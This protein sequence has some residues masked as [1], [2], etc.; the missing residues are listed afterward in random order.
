MHA[1]QVPAE[2]VIEREWDVAI[3]GCGPAGAVAAMELARRGVRVVA[4]ERHAFPRDKICGDALVPDACRVLERLGLFERVRAQSHVARR[5]LWI[6]PAGV[7]VPLAMDAL[8]AKRHAFD[9]LLAEAAAERGAV[10]ANANASAVRTDG[11][12]ATVHLRDG[13]EVRARVLVLATGADVRLLAS[14]GMVRRAMATSVAIRCYVR[15]RARVDDLVVAFHRLVPRGYAWIFPLGDGEYN[16]GCGWNDL[17]RGGANLR[18]ALD[19]FMTS[20]PLARELRAGETE[21]TPLA[22]AT[23]RAGLTGAQLRHSSNV[24]AIG[25][26]IGATFPLTGEGIGKAMETGERAAEVIAR[27][28]LAAYDAEIESLRYRYAGYFAAERW[29]I[30]PRLNDFLARIVRRR[31][32]MLKLLEGVLDETVDPHEVFSLRGLIRHIGV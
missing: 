2:A 5:V 24:I 4:L 11:E 13:G 8:V 6:S 19:A 27:G 1:W 20:F 10:I 16:V 14:L 32:S 29:L 30:R 7:E 18:E 28:E 22:G 9:A 25:E 21:R 23:L 31:P 17:S 15:S 3:V 12:I 26:T